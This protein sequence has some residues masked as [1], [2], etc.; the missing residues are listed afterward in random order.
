MR[1]VYLLPNLVTT[2]NLFCGFY[3]VIATIQGEF[4]SASYAILAAAFF[5][6]LDGRIARMARATSEFGV[7]YDS[8]SDLTSFGMAP[9][10]LF[11]QWVL[12]PFDRLGWVVCFLYVTCA[13]LRLARFNVMTEIVPKSD[14]QGLPSPVA[15]GVLATLVIFR[16][17]VTWPESSLL[18]SWIPTFALILVLGIAALMVS[19]VRFASFKEL[20]WRSRVG[21]QAIL[22]GVGGLVSILVKHEVMLFVLS[23]SY[24]LFGLFAALFRQLRTSTTRTQQD[25][26]R[27]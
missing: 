17:E 24:V 1:K 27:R 8:M 2:A 16:T 4:L 5:D 14:F 26:E 25:S 21:F 15:A 20:N 7:E 9:A 13:A 12:S 6:A 23:L 10:I 22:F 18:G 11:Y 19:N 3:S